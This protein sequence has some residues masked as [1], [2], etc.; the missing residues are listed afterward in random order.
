MSTL[1]TWLRRRDEWPNWFV[2]A[3]IIAGLLNAVEWVIQG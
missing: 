2:L 3:L 1:L